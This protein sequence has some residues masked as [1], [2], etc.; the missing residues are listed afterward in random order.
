MPPQA[1][2]TPHRVSSTLLEH[3]VAGIGSGVLALDANGCIALVNPAAR[4]H[5]GAP[6]PALAPGSPSGEDP[7]FAPLLAIAE[8]L[9]RTGETV[10]RKEVI[11]DTTDGPRVLGVTASLLREQGELVGK[12]FLFSDLTRIRELERQAELNQQLAQIGELTAGVVHEIRNPLSVISGMAELLQRRLQDDPRMR[13]NVGLILEEVDNLERLIK[14]FLVFSKPYEIEKNVCNPE[15][16]SVRTQRQVER[17]ARDKDVIV[18]LTVD[19]N[20][21][22]IAADT[23]KMVQAL[24]N[25]LRNAIEVSPPASHVAFHICKEDRFVCFRISDQGP[26]VDPA[27]GDGIFNAFVSKKQGGTGLGLSIVHRIV[28]GHGGTIRFFNADTGG[29]VF[30][31]RLPA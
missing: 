24:S 9:D 11:L 15:F 25:L 14:E 2:G 7:H 16:I 17:L 12:V 18:D 6:E 8:E 23:P 21:P 28:S 26:G 30:E 1:D 13:T 4:A 5:L 10:S 20:V 19:P 22:Q 27:L 3:I 31:V 29:A